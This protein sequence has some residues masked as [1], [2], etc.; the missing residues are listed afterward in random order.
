MKIILSRKGF[1][2]SNGGVPSP[3]F[4]YEDGTFGLYSLPIPLSRSTCG[5][6]D[7][8]WD[9]GNLHELICS[10]RRRKKTTLADPPHL[11]PD[12]V[13]NALDKRREGWRPVFGQ[14]GP[15]ETQLQ[16][17]GVNDPA[18]EPRNRPLFLF[19]GWYREAERLP[20]GYSCV[21]GRPNIHAIFGWL[22]VERKIILAGAQVRR[23]AD[24]AQVRRDLPWIANHPHIACGYYDSVLNAVYLAPEPGSKTDRLIL[25]G[26][27]TGLPASGMFRHFVPSIHT[28]TADGLT[29]RNWRLPSWFYR[30]GKPALG[31]H[32]DLARWT[33]PATDAHY[34]HLRSV[35]I[36]QEFV[37]ESS[38]HDEKQVFEWVECIVRAGQ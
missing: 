14:S 33:A 13:R 19:F 10:L 18:G 7:I 16:N 1:D 4:R 9:G 24:R 20:L 21:R 12:L 17:M 3:I 26:R 30:N 38:A 27:D 6:A 15:Q 36:G 2:S 28:L 31:M 29:R 37:F 23:D 25:N 11:D 32:T 34:A 5:Y 22:Q 8:R 35:D